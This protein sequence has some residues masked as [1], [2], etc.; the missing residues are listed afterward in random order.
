M[1]R[2]RKQILDSSRVRAIPEEGFSWIDRRFLRHGFADPLSATE[3][4]LYWFLCSAADRYGLSYYGDS[5]IR[6]ILKLDPG[7]LE[8]ARQGIIREKLV[9]YQAP[10]YQVL[11]LPPAPVHHPPTPPCG[12]RDSR[13]PRSSKG[14]L[15]PIREILR[16]MM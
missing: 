11:S 6:R 5:R 7:S 13:A 8:H 15:Q 10:L 14:T 16:D 4:L 1:G 9:L 2:I 3:I 12:T